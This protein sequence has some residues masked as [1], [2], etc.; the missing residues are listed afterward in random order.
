MKELRENAKGV[1]VLDAGDLLFKK[2]SGLI[3][4]NEV[5]MVTEKAH[6][7]IGSLNLMGYDA[8]GIGDDDLTLGKEFLIEIS[9]K[10]NSPFLSS[11]ILD[12]E[13]GKPIFQPYLVKEI[14]GLRIGIFSLLSPDV[15]SGP[16]DPRIKGLTLQNPIEVAQDMVKELQSKTDLVILL[17]HLGYSKDVEFAQNVPGV[18]LIV[19]GHTGINLSY[20]PIMK[21]TVILQAPPKGMYGAKF[22]LNFGHP[23]ST[24]YNSMTKRSY[25]N[26]INNLKTRLASKEVPE[27]QK[28]QLRTTKEGIERSLQQ[29]SGKNEFTNTISPLGEQIKEHPDI[30]KL[31]EAFKS[32]FQETAKSPPPK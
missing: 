20:P 6:L 29:L 7:I 13:S 1:L 30:E 9:K 28:A 4:E 21:N 11:N 17:S 32:N 26:N 10:A 27:V 19:G 14:N 25:E 3:P 15:F 31:V 16:S 18:H 23:E 5:K 24:F 22:D 12:E 8:M 2:F